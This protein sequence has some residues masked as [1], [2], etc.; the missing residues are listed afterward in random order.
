MTIPRTRRVYCL[1]CHVL[2]NWNRA[3]T[4]ENVH[5]MFYNCPYFL[6]SI[7]WYTCMFVFSSVE[8][9]IV[10]SQSCVLDWR[11]PV[12]P[13]GGHHGV[14]TTYSYSSFAFYSC[15]SSVPE[16]VV[17]RDRMDRIIDHLKWIK[18]LVCVHSCCSVCSTNEVD[19]KVSVCS[20]IWWCCKSINLNTEIVHI[21]YDI[22][23]QEFH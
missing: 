12:L 1:N 13:I 5:H 18:K 10:C 17:L 21:F 23:M 7:L 8:C 20:C 2:T 19:G 15:S 14:A 4:Q 9:E 6:V 11:L 22:K 16:V 3:P